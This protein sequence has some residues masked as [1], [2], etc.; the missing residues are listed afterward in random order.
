MSTQ[1]RKIAGGYEDSSDEYEQERELM[2]IP[3]G[4]SHKKPKSSLYPLPR[5][6]PFK[7]NSGFQYPSSSSSARVSLPPDAMA[8]S[9]SSTIVPEFAPSSHCDAQTAHITGP[10]HP[11]NPRGADLCKYS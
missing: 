3:L 6:A 5:L 4:Q 2:Q 10:G 8:S 7:P 1:K 11:S 9:R